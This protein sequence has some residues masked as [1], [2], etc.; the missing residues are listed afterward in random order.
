MKV[1]PK[2]VEYIE[3]NIFPEYEKNDKAHGI[4][5]IKEVIRRS[6]ELKNLLNIN[7]DDDLVYTIAACHDNG[8]YI[9]HNI[10]EQIAS[11]RFI[12]N[13]GFKQFFT[14][15]QRKIIAEAIQDHRSS[16]EDSPRSVYGELIS[17]ADRNST[18]EM[19]FIRSFYVGQ[20]RTPDMIVE[21]FLEFTHKRL[22]KRYSEEHSENMFFND[23]IYDKFL[24][25]MRALLKDEKKFK[26][27]YCH[28]NNIKNCQNTLIQEQ[29]YQ[30]NNI[31]TV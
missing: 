6:F 31:K 18:I 14:D 8:K 4:V 26:D 3:N 16:F 23:E 7:V 25:D 15:V 24:L 2:L 5:H 10:H 13:E 9:D 17:S 27:Y 19:V 12:E 21:D 22:S 30:D 20:W 11:Q 28:V 1:N 29:G